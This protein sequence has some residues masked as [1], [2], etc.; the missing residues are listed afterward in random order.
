MKDKSTP[1]LERIIGALLVLVGLAFALL[2]AFVKGRGLLP[3]DPMVTASMLGI[4][5]VLI[6]VGSRFVKS[7]PEITGAPTSDQPVRFL[8]KLRRPAELVVA[9]GTLFLLWRIVTTF[10]SFSWPPQP[11]FTLL[12]AA[13]AVIGPLITRIRT[14]GEFLF[15]T[16]LVEGWSPRTN[17]LAR[18]MFGVAGL[19]YPAIAVA[20]YGL[21]SYLPEPWGRIARLTDCLL[22]FILY[23]AQLSVLQFGNIRE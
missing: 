20:W 15:T 21:D 11:L 4:S 12:L 8:P 5:G 19:G 7:T 3:W 16:E 17:R 14:P 10:R 6:W 22:I 13:P 9:L 2:F 23:A 1:W 18:V